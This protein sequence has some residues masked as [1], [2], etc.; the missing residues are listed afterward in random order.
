MWPTQ[1]SGSSPP[2]SRWSD[3]GLRSRL[4]A[5]IGIAALLVG[6]SIATW[7]SIRGGQPSTPTLYGAARPGPAALW[8]WDGTTYAQRTVPATGPSSNYADLAYDRTHGVMVLWDH[9]CT[10]LV[11]G[12]QGG[13]VAHVNRTWTWDGNVWTANRTQS[14][15]T[16]AGQGAMFFDGKLGQVVYVNGA[17]QA[18]AWGGS[19]WES[20]ALP[21]GPSIPVPGSGIQS[22][23]FAAGYDEGRDALVLVLSN[24]TWLWDGSAWKEVAGGIAAGEVRADVH[25]V[26]DKAHHQLVYVGSRATWTWDGSGWQQ[27]VQPE[28]SA[29]TMAYDERRA[30]VLLVQQDSSA[31]NRTTCATTTWAWDSTAWAKVPVQRGPLLP[32]TR[33][34]AFGMP[35]AFDE[36]NGVMLL[37][38]SAS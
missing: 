1:V 12:F 23:T 20:L 16:A 5:I 7:L 29:G 9:G 34:G 13:C 2:T 25:V 6:A 3:R 27:H 33:S 18:W 38:A 14:S 26:D 15:P 11:M 10:S 21:G 30:G 37:F 32:L 36:A 31:C 19:G 28:I 24:A 22:S 8:T 35:M 17:G 4:F